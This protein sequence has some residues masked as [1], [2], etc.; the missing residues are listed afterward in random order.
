MRDFP[1]N[2]I[3]SSQST[4]T[5]RYTERGCNSSQYRSDGLD[6]K[7]PSVTVGH[8]LRFKGFKVLRSLRRIGEQHSQSIG[9]NHEYT[10][11][12]PWKSA[13]FTKN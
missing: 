9:N 4:H 12:Q 10:I 8:F 3:S 7:F 2:H 5:A 6:Y 11:I 13:K 1:L